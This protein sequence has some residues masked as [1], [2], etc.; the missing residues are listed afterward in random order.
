MTGDVG[1]S[2]RGPKAVVVRFT[3]GE[4]GRQRRGAMVSEEDPMGSRIGG[5]SRPCGEGACAGKDE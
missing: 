2:G 4:K 1:L 5:R 3:F